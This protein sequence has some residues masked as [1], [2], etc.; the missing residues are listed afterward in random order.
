MRECV[1][2]LRLSDMRKADS[3]RLVA[4]RIFPSPP[5]ASF[6]G[7]GFARLLVGD[8]HPQQAGL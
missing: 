4:D 7:R 8:D 6:V 3:L 5:I 1:A 2:T